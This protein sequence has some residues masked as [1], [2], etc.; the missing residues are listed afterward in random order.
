MPIA[1]LTALAI[2]AA[3][4]AAVK[5]AE[6]LGENRPFAGLLA[7][8][9]GAKSAAPANDPAQKSARDLGEFAALVRERLSAAGVQ[10]S[11]RFE[12]TA[13]ADGKLRVAGEH[14]KKQRIEQALAGDDELAA[15]FA[16]LAAS[17]HLDGVYLRH[18]EFAQ[19]YVSGA[20][21]TSNTPPV[22]TPSRFSVII[23]GDE[24]S[25]S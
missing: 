14:P 18:A 10:T 7:N 22:I 2:P 15:A 13:D 24:V 25:I 5:L 6:R 9:R 17:H 19:Q 12:L 11:I 4:V 8:V 20:I 21:P 23:H 3:G 16:Q 1:P